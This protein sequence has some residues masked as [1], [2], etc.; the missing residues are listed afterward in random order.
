MS[1]APNFDEDAIVAVVDLVGRAGA[2]AFELGYLDDDVP[3]D[4][5]R[6]WAHA[7]YGGDRITVEDMPGP[8]EAAEA[9]ARE[10]LTGGRCR[11][12]RLVALSDEAA[13]AY[14]ET[15]MVDGSTWTAQEAATAG[16]CRWTRKGRR[17]EMG[18]E[19]KQ[20]RPQRRRRRR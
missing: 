8:V 16:Q 19:Q 12:G 13:F 17:W 3:V 20:N 6:W 4:K 10:I 1:P 18:C 2:R 9:L 14:F 15:R 7:D 11:C 5:A